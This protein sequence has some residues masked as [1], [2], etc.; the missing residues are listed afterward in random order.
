MPEKAL[1]DNINICETSSHKTIFKSI[2]VKDL[3]VFYI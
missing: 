1:K 2:H 3:Y